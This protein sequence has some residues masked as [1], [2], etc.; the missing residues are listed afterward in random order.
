MTAIRNAIIVS[1]IALPSIVI[2]KD[3]TR[4]YESNRNLNIG[5][6]YYFPK[7]DHRQL[8]SAFAYTLLGREFIN[9]LHYSLYTGFIGTCA[10]GNIV[11]FDENFNHVKYEP[12]ASGIGPAVAIK[13]DFIR[14]SKQYFAGDFLLGIISYNK[15]FPPGGDIYNF[16]RKYGVSLGHE[17]N[18]T[19][20]INL[21]LRDIHISNS[22]GLGSYNPSYEGWGFCPEVIS[23]IK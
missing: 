10:W 6:E 18:N 23:L 20:N 4:R 12:A 1:L 2:A 5:L 13:V 19:F 15:H 3:N 14:F 9:Q 16:F 22:Q 17:I 11:Q 21:G 8:Q 7:D